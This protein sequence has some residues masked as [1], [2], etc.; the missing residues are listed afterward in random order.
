MAKHLRRLAVM[1]SGGD[2]PGMNACIRAIVR[3]GHYHGIEILGVRRGYVGLVNGDL[4]PLGLRDVGGK[5]QEGGTFLLS[6]R[7]PEF[8]DVDIQMRAIEKMRRHSVDALIV[9][10]GDGS[11]T[12]AYALHTA[13]FPVIGIPGSIDNDISGTDMAIGI[14]TA[15]NTILDAIDRLRDTA[16]SHGRAFVIETM[17][18]SCGYLALMA[19]MT[20]GAEI[21]HLPEAELELGDILERVELAWR[22]GKSH[23]LIVVAEGATFK[24]EEIVQFLNREHQEYEVR[25][26]ILGHVQR[27]GRPTHFDRFLAT[28]M[29]V[30]AVDALMGQD[31]GVMIALK[32]TEMIH[33]PLEQVIGKVK[34][35]P[36]AYIESMRILAQ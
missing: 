1:T 10:G 29:G 21:V 32:G 2:A 31:D 6:T 35:L 3:Y 17:G 12:G 16:S 28:R 11:L 20:G 18:R 25:A 27:G 7:L 23:V 26:T 5:L 14:D 33:V 36:S 34:P 8:V 13:G 22:R 15:L 24:A 19:G 30:A 9:I 4:Y